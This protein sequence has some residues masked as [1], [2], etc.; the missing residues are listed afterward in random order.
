MFEG[1]D[2]FVKFEAPVWFLMLE[3]DELDEDDDNLLEDEELDEDELDDE[4][5]LQLLDDE[6]ADRSIAEI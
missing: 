5:L 3:D 4:L 6:D 2:L 1:A